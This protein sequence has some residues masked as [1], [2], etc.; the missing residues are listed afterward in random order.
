MNRANNKFSLIPIAE[1]LERSIFG[2][3][4]VV[5]TEEVETVLQ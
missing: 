4:Y 1:L 5:A 2:E 3:D